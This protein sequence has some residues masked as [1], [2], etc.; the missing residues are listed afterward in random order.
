MDVRVRDHRPRGWFWL[1]DRIIDHFASLLTHS[2]LSVYV[3][4]CRR[5]NSRGQSYASIADLCARLRV[6]RDTVRLANQ[7]LVALQLIRVESGKDKGKPNLITL[8]Q[9]GGVADESGTGVVA[10][11]G[12]PNGLIRHPVA[13]ESGTGV[14]AKSGTPIMKDNNDKDY[15][16]RTTMKDKDPSFS[17]VLQSLSAIGWLTPG[18]YQD[19]DREFRPI[20]SELC[21]HPR[22]Q[23]A[24]DTV[25][26]DRGRWPVKAATFVAA[27][28]KYCFVDRSG[29]SNPELEQVVA[30]Y[31]WL[32]VDPVTVTDQDTRIVFE[33][34]TREGLEAALKLV[35]SLVLGLDDDAWEYRQGRP[36]R[37]IVRPVVRET[38]SYRADRVINQAREKGILPPS[39]KK[40]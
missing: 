32:M 30:F 34:V 2:Q 25:M 27:M 5:A 26:T 18:K 28:Q 13:D 20:L 39:E 36:L 22:W 10:K 40:P 33:V 38:V 14:V 37:F 7:R 1:D 11:S 21:H 29:S 3:Y 35:W 15:P 23:T 4:Y 31:R 19:I 6:D 24:W 16:L 9:T 12:T 17:R 8:L